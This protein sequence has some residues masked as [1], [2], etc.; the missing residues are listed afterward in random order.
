MGEKIISN[1][2]SQTT[3]TSSDTAFDILTFFD[4]N[5]N[6]IDELVLVPLIIFTLMAENGGNLNGIDFQGGELLFVAKDYG[7]GITFWINSLG[8]LLINSDDSSS[9]EIDGNGYLIYS[10]C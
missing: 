9:Y 7:T 6:C 2:P 10:F 3:L 1:V 8:E 4:G 5:F